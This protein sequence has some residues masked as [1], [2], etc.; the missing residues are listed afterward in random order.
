MFYLLGTIPLGI[1]PLTGPVAHSID[2][3]ATFAQHAVTRG[4]PVLQEIGEELDT[5]SFDFYFSEEFCTPS[6]ELAK[7]KAA[8][9]MKSPMPLVLGSGGFD[10]KRYVI[11]TL[12][13][14]VVK[15]SLSGA[16]IRIE[17]TISLLEDP[18]AGGLT[19]LI[20]SIVRSAASAVG[21]KAT[22]NPDVRK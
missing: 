17:A 7:L 16:P 11:D 20:S 18:V 9:A 5:Q 14:R 8:F 3:A 15:T 6:V 22:S 13:Y 19:G 10:G 2:H 12:S 1:A 21:K 4:K